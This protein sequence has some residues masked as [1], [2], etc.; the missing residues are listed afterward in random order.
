M[1]LARIKVP[2]SNDVPRFLQLPG[3]NHFVA[4]EDVARHN[5]D[6]LLPEMEIAS[7]YMFRLTR[8]AN[9]ER[10]EEAP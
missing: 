6:L 3:R 10:D 1:S 4:L 2:T 5:L 8:N 9:T 7:C